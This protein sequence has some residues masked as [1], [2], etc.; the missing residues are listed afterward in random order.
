MSAEERYLPLAS[1]KTEGEYSR[2]DPMSRLRVGTRLKF[3]SER[4]RYQVRA[5]SKR[6]AVCT[7][8]FNLR[9]TVRYTIIDFKTGDR[10]RPGIGG[11]TDDECRQMLDRLENGEGRVPYFNQM[12]LDIEPASYMKMLMREAGEET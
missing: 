7:K 5:V 4:Q 8:P 6:F 10:T 1:L 11:H 3:A 12:V 9:R 2:F